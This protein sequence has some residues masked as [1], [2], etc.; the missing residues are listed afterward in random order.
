MKIMILTLLLFISL[1]SQA[2]SDQFISGINVQDMEIEP[3]GNRIFGGYIDTSSSILKLDANNNILWCKRFAEISR[4][5]KMVLH[6]GSI[7]SVGMKNNELFISKMNSNGIIE[8]NQKSVNFSNYLSNPTLIVEGN[9]IFITCNID[10]YIA[11]QSFDT[12][13][14][15]LWSKTVE[16]YNYDFLSNTDPYIYENHLYC[17]FVEYNRLMLTKYD[18][19]G[20]QKWLK[21]IENTSFFPFSV[22][23]SLIENGTI[24]FN[25]MNNNYEPFILEADTSGIIIGGKEYTHEYYDNALPDKLIKVNGYLYLL[26]TA[27]G[28]LPLPASPSHVIAELDTNFN[29]NR[30]IE[31][32]PGYSNNAFVRSDL[33]YNGTDFHLLKSFGYNKDSVE[34]LTMNSIDQLFCDTIHTLLF[35]SSI[36]GS[37]INQNYSG[38][39]IGIDFININLTTTNQSISINASCPLMSASSIDNIST[40]HISPNPN[41]GQFSLEIPEIKNDTQLIIFNSIGQIIHSE[42]IS[43]SENYKNVNLNLDSGIYFLLIESENEI[44]SRSKMIVE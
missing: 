31:F 23:P 20:N 43:P 32:F 15:I 22:N 27:D 28:L 3:N 14:N 41:N 38:D 10:K 2:Q 4:I 13:G 26:Y 25:G 12:S 1:F 17:L 7:Y 8:W 21:S 39:S 29:F 42:K 30:Q 35:E 33:E 36:S 19:S 11:I 37:F 6:N 16:C 24:I 34:I 40:L 18:F 44:I 9:Q 5:E